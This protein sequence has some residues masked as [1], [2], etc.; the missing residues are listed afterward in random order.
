[1]R[2]RHQH[3]RCLECS[4]SMRRINWD[5]VI[6]I[7]ERGTSRSH[8]PLLFDAQFRWSLPITFLE[9]QDVQLRTSS[10]GNTSSAWTSSTQKSDGATGCVWNHED[11]NTPETGIVYVNHAIPSPFVS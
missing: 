11:V 10:G 2:V 1:M 8:V 9:L 6:P 5:R 3:R 4:S 7:D